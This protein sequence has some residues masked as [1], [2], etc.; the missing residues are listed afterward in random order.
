MIRG[1]PTVAA[2]VHSLRSGLMQ[3]TH[4]RSK[5]MMRNLSF[6]LCIGGF[7]VFFF[8][9]I[10]FLLK[11]ARREGDRGG[12]MGGGQSFQFSKGFSPPS[13][14]FHLY[15]IIQVQLLL[16]LLFVFVPG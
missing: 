11:L 2:A 4:S 8:L 16:L 15:C 5:D 10:L 1:L 12:G 6:F 7:L 13:S 14:P 9:K 3:L